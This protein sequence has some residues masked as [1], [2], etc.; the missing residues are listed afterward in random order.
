MAAVRAAAT[1]MKRSARTVLRGNWRGAGASLRP[2][3][4]H[5]AG[6]QLARPPPCRTRGARSPG[7]T[8]SPRPRA[9]A[10]QPRACRPPGNPSTARQVRSR[11]PACVFPRG[12]EPGSAGCR[13][14]RHLPSSLSSTIISGAPCP[15]ELGSAGRRAPTR[16][17]FGGAAG[18]QAASGL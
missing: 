9:P 7:L 8:H 13:D 16:A 14:P 10:P 17:R 2:A 3:E 4:H 12:E 5:P 15:A 6:V 11:V 1:K 18:P